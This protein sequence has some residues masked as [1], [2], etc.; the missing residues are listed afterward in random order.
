MVVEKI[1]DGRDLIQM[2]G[3]AYFY[4][5]EV[6]SYLER[7]ARDFISAGSE[8]WRLEKDVLFRG[9]NQVKITYILF[10]PTKYFKKWKQYSALPVVRFADDIRRISSCFC[11]CFFLKMLGF[12]LTWLFLFAVVDSMGSITE[13]S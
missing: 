2:E 7:S 6:L 9:L 1:E 8:G 13:H 11:F 12:T 4:L 5:A 3:E 10:F